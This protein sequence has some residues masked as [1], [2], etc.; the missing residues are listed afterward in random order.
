MG[1]FTSGRGFLRLS[2]I[3]KLFKFILTTNRPS[4]RD[5][6][7]NSSNLI[8]EFQS[9][10]LTMEDIGAR[11]VLNYFQLFCIIKFVV[12]HDDRFYMKHHLFL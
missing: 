12:S 9:S 10:S 4:V 8:S 11:R 2:S 1:G 6:V 3:F 5:N 7:P